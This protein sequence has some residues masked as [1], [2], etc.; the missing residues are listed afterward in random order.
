MP[1]R[2]LAAAFVSVSVVAFAACGPSSKTP[3][4]PDIVLAENPPRPPPDANANTLQVVAMKLAPDDGGAPLISLDADGTVHAPDGTV[5]GKVDGVHLVDKNGKE[6]YAVA[7]DGALISPRETKQKASFDADGKIVLVAGGNGSL[8]VRDDGTPVETRDGKQ[9]IWKAHFVGFDKKAKRTAELL[10]LLAID[11][12]EG[13]VG[14]V[15]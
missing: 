1:H 15:K 5:V 8:E 7:P 13:N 12:A 2:P 11:L 4:N 6:S 3:K 14:Q 10:C 9:K